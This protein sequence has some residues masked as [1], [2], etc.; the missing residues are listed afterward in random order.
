[1]KVSNG[2]SA[3]P[4]K[5]SKKQVDFDINVGL[6]ERPPWFCRYV[7]YLFELPSLICENV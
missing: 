5:D 4:S 7:L 1:M 2:S 6:S 3:K